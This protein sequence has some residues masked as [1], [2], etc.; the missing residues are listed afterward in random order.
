M[1]YLIDILIGAGGSLIAKELWSNADPVSQWLVRKAVQR[2]PIE[3]RERR[4]EEWAADVH[5]MPS[6]FGKLSWAVG[7]HWAATIA[8]AP[9]WQARRKL[10]PAGSLAIQGLSGI[11]TAVKRFRPVLSV[12]VKVLSAAEQ[13]S[14]FALKVVLRVGLLVLLVWAI[15]IGT[16]TP[17]TALQAVDEAREQL[18]HIISAT[19]PEAAQRALDEAREQLIELIAIPTEPK[20]PQHPQGRP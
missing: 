20:P 5:D 9:A 16:R 1:G 19:T 17:K 14:S 10:V 18:I 6:A 13:V 2:L 4:L 15:Q 12:A 11:G 3:E 8:N 7:C